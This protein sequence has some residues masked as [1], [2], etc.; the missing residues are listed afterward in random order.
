MI[1]VAI[2]D[3]SSFT[4]RLL[5]SYFESDGD[6]EVVGTAHDA[7]STREL[8]RSRRPDVL[9]LDLEMPGGRGL[10]LLDDII[11]AT[12]VPVVVISGVTRRA[13][14]T[15]LRA[16]E[17]GAVDFVLKY[18]P[19]APVAPAT[20]RREILAKVKAAATAKPAPPMRFEARPAHEPARRSGGAAAAV[21]GAPQVVVIGA[22]TGG[23]QALRELIMQ[24][25]ATFATPGVIVQ[26]LPASFAGAFTAQVGRYSHLPVELA[27][28]A[29]RLQPGQLLVAPG[30]RHLVVHENGRIELCA[31]AEAD[32]YRPSIDTAMTSAAEVYGRGAV[33]VVLSGMGNDGAEGLRRIRHAG[34]KGYVQDPATC[35]IGS[36]PS[37]AIER[38]GA[39]Y[40]AP[41][42]RLGKLL[43]RRGQA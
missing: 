15:T 6:C 34:G 23:P 13:A 43:A 37:R 9:T 4:C 5:H 17:L 30:G 19:G 21:D 29:D 1:R 16:L 12:A 7:A 14:A 22:S 28:T 36:M 10:D 18:T 38:A 31:A 3:D 27:K 35:V 8:V 25:P 32:T 11:G 41:P 20:L 2:A 24:L 40:V 26:H 33:G 39:D 42:D